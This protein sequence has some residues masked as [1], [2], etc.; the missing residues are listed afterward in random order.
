M[1]AW[2]IW[3][4]TA[5]FGDSEF[6]VRALSVVST[7]VTS[8]AV[9]ATAR[10]LGLGEAIASRGAIWFNATILVGVGAI[11]ITPELAL[12]DV[13]GAGRMGAGGHPP[14]RN[15]LAVAPRRA[16]RRPR[17][18]LEVHEPV[19]RRRRAP[20]ADRRPRRA[21]LV[22]E[23]MA[24]GRGHRRRPRLPAGA[25]RGT[26]T[27]TGSRSR[28]Q[29]GRV[30]AEGIQ[31]RYVGEFIA[32][33]I[34]LLNPLIAVFVGLGVWLGLE[35]RSPAGGARRTRAM[36][37]LLALC[38]PA[39]RLYGRPFLPRAGAG[40]LACPGL[41]RA[42]APR[43]HRR[44]DVVFAV[45]GR[46][47]EGGGAGRH[48][49]LG[50]GAPV[51]RLAARR[52]RSASAP[53]PSAWSAGAISRDGRGPDGRSRARAGS[54]PPTTAS[55]A[56]WPSTDP[57]RNWSS[58]STSASAICSTRSTRASTQ[59]PALL[60]LPKERTDLRKFRR[61][62]ELARA[63]GRDRAHR[64]G[65]PRGGLRRLAGG[66]RPEGYPPAGLPLTLRRSR[67]RLA[68][69]NLDFAA[70]EVAEKRVSGAAANRAA[71]PRRER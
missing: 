12:G 29:F 14:D 4:S 67:C 61:C 19:P 21:P 11:L 53:R 9:F 17:L 47:G 13:L 66:G 23:P 60:V 27:T 56:N 38:A 2:W 5:L 70:R 1:V 15:R 34:G 55:P 65:R 10:N 52:R 16:L 24:V 59:S 46:L 54:R 33:Q 64:T 25:A 18:P 30:A 7:A 3:A 69:G 63:G 28:K 32:S 45:P 36:L 62:F 50:P 8:Y 58:R 71:R 6:G 22:P 42:R 44:R 26:P 31:L 48:R 35:S 41:S 40:E 37:F 39:D 43:R 68:S 20:L 51:L 57:A 49:G